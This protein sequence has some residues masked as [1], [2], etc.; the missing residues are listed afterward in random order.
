M[1]I[2]FRR[3]IL[4]AELD[5][6]LECDRR[7]F[8]AFPAD[9]FPP[10]VW[11]NLESYWMFADGVKAGCCAFER[12]CDYDGRV[13]PGYLYIASTGVLPEF[14]G[15]GLGRKQKEWEIDYAREHGF[16][17]IVTHMRKSNLKMRSLNESFGFKF[18]CFEPDYYTTPDEPAVVMELL[19]APVLL[20]PEAR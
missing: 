10:D 6:L 4:P 14:Q 15:K 8:G 17:A 2:E 18:R 13:R 11:S 5:D 12:N 9:L 3:S 16:T 20:A 1:K 7:I 19:L